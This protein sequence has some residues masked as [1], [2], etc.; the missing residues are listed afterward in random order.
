MGDSGA[1]VITRQFFKESFKNWNALKNTPDWIP[2]ID[3]F[4]DKWQDKTLSDIYT[5]VA[6]YYP[7]STFSQFNFSY[8]QGQIF[9]LELMGRETD[10]DIDFEEYFF[11]TLKDTNDRLHTSLSNYTYFIPAGLHHS[12]IPMKEFYTLENEGVKF[13]DWVSRLVEGGQPKPVICTDCEAE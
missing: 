9:F 10:E 12:F 7:K 11:D 3:D 8:D 13:T 2:E 4:K 5:A 6:N 1:G